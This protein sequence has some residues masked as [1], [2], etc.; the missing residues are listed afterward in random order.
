MNSVLRRLKVHIFCLVGSLDAK[1]WADSPR[2]LSVREL[3]P[4]SSVMEVGAD[5]IEKLDF[6]MLGQPSLLVASFRLPILRFWEA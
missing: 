5:C 4:P 3:H 1:K 6:S 2:L